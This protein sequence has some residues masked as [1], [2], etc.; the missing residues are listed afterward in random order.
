VCVEDLH[1]DLE[2][3]WTPLLKSGD[4]R[5]DL[6]IVEFGMRGDITP[7]WGIKLNSRALLARL[8][9]RE[10]RVRSYDQACSSVGEPIDR[11]TVQVSAVRQ[12]VIR[13]GQSEHDVPRAGVFNAYPE[14]VEV[15]Y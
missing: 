2:R 12:Q 1:N 9:H 11:A 8:I 6:I 13:V 3:G 7:R 14:C 15:G 5:A 4:K 10:A